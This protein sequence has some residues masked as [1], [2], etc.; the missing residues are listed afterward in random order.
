[1]ANT[2]EL[3]T[4][5]TLSSNASSVTFSSI[6]QTYTDLLFRLSVRSTG[7]NGTGDVNINSNNSGNAIRLLSDG[8]AVSSANQTP[9]FFFYGNSSSATA[10]TF[11][12][13]DLYIPNY[14]NTSNY[15]S[16]SLD[17]VSENNGTAALAVL[18]AGIWNNTSA[19]TSVSFAYSAGG[20]QLVS[21]S[22]FYLY[23][24]KNS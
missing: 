6:P 2:Y 17:M 22:T 11:A 20:E 13:N 19:I 12:S 24:I 10:N 21:G 4:S 7:T 3:I 16:V 18:V 23:G 15:K 14:T 8:S 5:Q 9:L 1:M